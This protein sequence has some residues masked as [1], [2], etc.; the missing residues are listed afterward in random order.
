MTLLL[1]THTFLFA[2]ADVKK[3]SA[4]VRSLLQDPKN[5]R[6]LSVVSL[7]EIAVK[8]QIGKLELPEDPAFYQKHLSLLHASLLTVE[9]RHIFELM[10]LPLLHRDPFDRL[11]LAQAKVD[12]LTLVTRDNAMSQYDVATL[13]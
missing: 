8:I 9:P 4:K 1:D 10:R 3:L 12:S 7:W 5:E 6:V 13:W 11:L 2:I